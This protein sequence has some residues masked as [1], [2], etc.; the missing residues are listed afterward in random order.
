[1]PHLL[2][3]GRPE[4]VVLSVIFF[5]S[6]LAYAVWLFCEHY[7][8]AVF[9]NETLKSTLEQQLNVANLN[10]SSVRLVVTL[11][12]EVEMFDPAKP[13][14]GALFSAEPSL[15]YIPEYRELSRESNETIIA[16][17]L[18][19]ASIPLGVLKRIKIGDSFYVDGGYAD[20]G[21]ILPAIEAGFDEIFVVHTNP[22]G[23][24]NGAD[25]RTAEGLRKRLQA[26]KR[27]FEVYRLSSSLVDL[28]KAK[29]RRWISFGLFPPD[30][31]NIVL[32]P[33]VKITAKVVHIVPSVS[34]GS[35]LGSI[36]FLTPT[37]TTRLI[38][39]GY[40]DASEAIRAL[41]EGQ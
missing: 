39:L 35:L 9:N 24:V 28:Y 8:L 23:E 32:C 4:S 11:A 17:L 13:A 33:E 38:A 2:R 12:K 15:S 6:T 27:T 36:L 3:S 34:L 20:N 18:A 5:P 31:S 14:S 41:S 37:R 29:Y 19:T 22:R 25:I 40:S 26:L 21:P 7:N 30:K 10:G 1:M 16:C